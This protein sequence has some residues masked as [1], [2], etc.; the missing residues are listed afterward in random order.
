MTELP[1]R[2]RWTVHSTEFEAPGPIGSGALC[3]SGPDPLVPGQLSSG[4]SPSVYV[5]P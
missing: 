4:L 1:R 5:I 3:F 2:V